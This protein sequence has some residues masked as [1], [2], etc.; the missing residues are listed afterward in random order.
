MSSPA[1]ESL[2]QGALHGVLP[3]RQEQSEEPWSPELDLEP[4]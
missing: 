1:G 3:S 4:G 2:R